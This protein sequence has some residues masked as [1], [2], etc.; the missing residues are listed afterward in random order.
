MD[1]FTHDNIAVGI[2][3]LSLAMCEH[4]VERGESGAELEEG[5]I[6]AWLD[7]VSKMKRSSRTCYVHSGLAGEWERR[8]QRLERPSSQDG[9]LPPG[10][11]G[12][13]PDSWDTQLATAQCIA[14]LL[15]QNQEID[16]S[17]KKLK[18]RDVCEEALRILTGGLPPDQQPTRTGGM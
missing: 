14:L 2:M 5:R 8:A 16:A 18:P 17:G 4:V 13:P 6:F 1:D 9:G 11:E 10:T 12:H 7:A 15:A 3:V